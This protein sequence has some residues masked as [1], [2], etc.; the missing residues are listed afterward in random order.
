MPKAELVKML[1]PHLD[2]R[3]SAAN[4]FSTESEKPRVIG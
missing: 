4:A 2:S 1:A 3:A